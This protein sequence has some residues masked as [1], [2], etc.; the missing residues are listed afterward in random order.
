MAENIPISLSPNRFDEVANLVAKADERKGII[1]ESPPWGRYNLLGHPLVRFDERGDYIRFPRRIPSH[2][3]IEP[4]WLLRAV[5][6]GDFSGI[7]ELI[8]MNYPVLLPGNLLA[9]R[10]KIET[11]YGMALSLVNLCCEALEV[12]SQMIKEALVVHLEQVPE[13]FLSDS[14]PHRQPFA[15]RLAETL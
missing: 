8:G 2:I 11:T 9:G 14:R 12:P 3:D 13:A 5:I 4:K 15:P 7:D 10:I 1:E 6:S